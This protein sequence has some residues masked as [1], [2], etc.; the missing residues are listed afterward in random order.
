MC[1]CN[2]SDS[3]RSRSV[4]YCKKRVWLGVRDDFRFGC[5]TLPHPI[6]RHALIVK[7]SA[8]GI[9]EPRCITVLVRDGQN[10]N[11]GFSQ[12]PG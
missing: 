6:C 12:P 9:R 7:G 3:T 5:G 8:R 10:G 11:P 2:H 4:K 1:R